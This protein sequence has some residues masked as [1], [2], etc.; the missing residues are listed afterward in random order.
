M[1][2]S[3]KRI[4]SLLEE[5]YASRVNNLAHSVELAEQA[6]SLSRAMND[7]ALTG[8]SLNQ[9]SL[10]FMIMG[11]NEES[12]ALAQEAIQHFEELNDEKGIA[13]AKYNIAGIYYKTDNFH[14]GLVYL[15][16]CLGI[17]RKFNDYHNQSRVEK[18]LGTIYEYFGDQNNAVKSYENAIA[19]AK[20]AMDLN[21]ESNAYNNLSGIYLKQNRIDEAAELIERSVSIKKQTGDTRGYAFAIYGKG[22]V[23]AKKGELQEAERNYMEAFRI[24]QEMGE[25]LGLGMTY[26]KLGSLYV[27]M[28]MLQKAKEIAE[29]GITFSDRYNIVIIKFKCDYL[30]YRIYK[31]ENNAGAALDYLERYLHQRESVINT[32]TLKVIENYDLITRMKTLET[33]AQLQREK[34]EII[35][36][37]N[38]AEESAR[39]RQE[40]LSTM[41]HEIRTPLNAVITI[42]SLLGERADEEDKHLLHSLKFASNNLLRIINDILDF[43]KLES[44][45]TKLET[46]QTNFKQLLENI[47]RTYDSMAREKGLKLALKTDVAMADSYELDETKLSQILGNLISNAIKFTE[48]GR[49]DMEVECITSGPQSDRLLFRISDTGEGIPENFLEE[50]FESFSQTKPITTRKQGGTGL[51][52]AIVKKLVELHGSQIYVSSTT[53]QGSAFYFELEFKKTVVP[54]KITEDFSTQLKGRAALLAEDND[55]NAF[56][57]RKLLSRWGVITE[58]ASNGRIALEMSRS[59]AFDFILMDIHMPEMNGFD[60][61][62]EIRQDG[63]PNFKT[64]IFALTADITAPQHE[65]YTSYFN[66]FLWKPLQLEKLYEALA[67]VTLVR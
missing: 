38:R 46:R 21:L 35:E 62:R 24:H 56:V 4:T 52:L 23:H 5:A 33:E 41:S 37:K 36:K 58:H 6:L 14:L 34:A 59:K 7:R 65:E 43:T 61:T 55:I 57:I 10:Y 67:G 11:R 53:G 63:N 28:G 30:L 2:E 40:F 27:E 64:P 54:E 17:Y 47:W 26:H 60:A 12:T 31:L 45:K 1:T 49:V 18:S 42:I 13:D 9:L 25:R 51:G 15:I 48:E 16:D 19:S 29:E 20:N 50:I 22:K 66:G 39:V 8:Q 32:Q 3:K 44:G